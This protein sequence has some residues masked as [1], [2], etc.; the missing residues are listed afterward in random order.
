MK[1][2]VCAI[3]FLSAALAAPL[4]EVEVRGTDAVLAALVRISLPFGVGDEPG[5]L[6]QARAAVLGTGYFRDARVTLEGSKLIVE[7]TP[8][9]TITKVAT[10]AK[11][12]PES[13]FLRY[14]ESEQAI[15]VGSTFNPN[16]ATEAAAAIARIYRQEGNLPFEPRVTPEAKDVTGGVELTFTIDETP[17][18]SR[19]ELGPSSYVP[20][21][22]LE[23]L[24][25]AIP[26]E[27][28]FN[29]ERFREAITRSGELY[30]TAGYRGSGVDLAQTV[31]DGEVL[32]VSFGELK[33]AEINPGGLDISSLGLKV[34]DPFNWDKVLDGINALSRQL[35]RVVEFRPERLENDG[36]RLNFQAG[37]QRFGAITAVRLEGNTAFPAA[38]LQAALRLKPGDE[39]NP[40]LAQ[41]DFARILGLYRNAGVFIVEQPTPSFENGVYVQRVREV[42]IAGYQLNPAPTRTEPS[43]FLREMPPVGSL[44]TQ[45]GIRNGITNILRTGLVS[46]PPIPTIQP[47]DQ[48]DQVT[49]VLP[50]REQRTG[51]FTPSI[52]A[53]SVSGSW[54]FEGNIGFRDT[55]L[56]G[57]AH[58]YDVNLGLNNN[59]AG[60]ILNFT[61]GYRIPWLYLDFADFKRVRTALNFSLYSTPS[62]NVSFKLPQ[63]QS[64]GG[65]PIDYNGDG[66]INADDKPNWEYTERRTGFGVGISRP[67]SADL[68]NLR[69]N[70]GVSYEFVQT[71]L[72]EGDP[73][74]PRCYG[75][76]L[77]P[78]GT[79]ARVELVP[80]SEAILAD[81]RSQFV[82]ALQPYQTLR[83]DVGATFTQLNSPFFPTQ[84]YLV[85]GAT[86]LGF[87][88]PQSGGSSTFVP[89]TITGRTYFPLD[90]EN[91][92][93][94]MLRLSAGT[95]LGTPQASQAFSLGGNQTDLTTLRGYDTKF[96]DGGTTVLNGTVEYAYDFGLSPTGGTQL[97][98]YVFTD[99]GSLWPSATQP[100]GL[101][102]G[103][104][105]G[106]QLNL[107]LLGALLPPI[108]L[109]YGFSERN[110]TGKFSIRFG[111][112]F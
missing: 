64:F 90:T 108:R 110:P 107:D 50:I 31:L 76:S 63:P 40:A 81:A 46:E 85:T 33:I 73:N 24:F 91:R 80:C 19:V 48:P 74:R 12:F 111:G 43:V 87:S 84:G 38:Q 41:E 59:D 94:L 56:W 112:S 61:A 20:R 93:A 39:Y 67:I 49:L 103:L 109:D 52:G 89:F 57:L 23:P 26:V 104:G 45:S 66:A 14:L 58:Q 36:V 37:A 102:A 101:Y 32:K 86:G 8:N 28:K 34:G 88:F 100:Q 98:G 7:V 16:R 54:T 10:T 106:L 95:I 97:Y 17:T 1:R 62:G 99:F 92:Q 5:D 105:F 53:S 47:T 60:Q 75:R 55:N 13:A 29:F 79:I 82:G 96:L 35:S 72:E 51:A 27:G 18:V 22:Q 69:L 78:D 71:F 44:L 11:I 77:N 42:K 6:G 9:P 2:L 30:A 4:Q 83:F 25:A 68:P 65:S 21:G 70:A 15:G 3:L